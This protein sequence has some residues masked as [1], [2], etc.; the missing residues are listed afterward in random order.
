MGRINIWKIAVKAIAIITMAAVVA[1]IAESYVQPVTV[2]A[3]AK[4]QTLYDVF[5]ERSG[6]PDS[7]MDKE[8]MRNKILKK[9]LNT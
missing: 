3:D 9:K 7:F 8:E 6:N 1:G 2:V 4:Y 5:R